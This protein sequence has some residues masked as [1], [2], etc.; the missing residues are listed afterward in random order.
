MTRK[1]AFKHVAQIVNRSGTSF[2]WSMRLLP[3]KRRLGIYSIYA[4]CR[5][6]D[7]IADCD[8]P[9]ST[10]LEKLGEWRQEI[11][12]VFAG[13]PKTL[14]GQALQS[15]AAVFRLKKIDFLRVLDGMEQDA[16]LEVRIPDWGSLEEYM[17][18]VSCSVGRLSNPIFGISGDKSEKLAKSL[19]QAL[20]LTNIIRDLVEDASNNRLYIPREMISEHRICSKIPLDVILHPGFK[21]IYERMIKRAETLF[22]QASSIISTGNRKNMVPASLMLER[23]W[24][25]LKKLKKT[26]GPTCG[27][28]V[29]LSKLEIIWLLIRCS[30]LRWR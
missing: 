4:F 29:A 27:Q 7:D 16:A 1:D 30:I 24:R 6:V 23:Y 28:T 20:Q 14:I 25:V 10:K 18:C 13:A 26:G 5:E 9:P 21:K 12:R 11:H 17:D 19:G 2:Y 3:R 15:S 8:L 22:E